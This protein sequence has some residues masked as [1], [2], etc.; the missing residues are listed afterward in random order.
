MLA[1]Y[2]YW[3]NDLLYMQKQINRKHYQRGL[4]YT[5]LAL[6]S[7]YRLPMPELWEKHLQGIKRYKKYGIKKIL[8]RRGNQTRPIHFKL[9]K[10]VGLRLRPL[11]F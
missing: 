6:I 9:S 4:I 1:G 3:Y 5:L 7:R 2:S 10:G 11:R 8:G